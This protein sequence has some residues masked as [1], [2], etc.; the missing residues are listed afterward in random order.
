MFASLVNTDKKSVKYMVKRAKH[1]V[2]K[3]RHVFS[4]NLIINLKQSFKYDLF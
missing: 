3:K 4:T 1:F 2:F